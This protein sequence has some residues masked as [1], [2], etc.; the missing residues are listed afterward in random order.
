MYPPSGA[1]AININKSD[2]KRLNDLCYLNDTLIEFGLK[3][4]VVSHSSCYGT[5]H[6]TDSGWLTYEK[7]NRSLLRRSMCSVRSFTRS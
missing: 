4:A 3:C 6:V 2:F 7:T 5:N 1:G